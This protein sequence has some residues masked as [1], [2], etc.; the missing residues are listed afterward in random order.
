[1]LKKNNG[2]TLIELI[3][4][5]ALISIMAAASVPSIKRWVDSYRLND[6]VYQLKAS[7]AHAKLTSVK[8]GINVR[9][10]YTVGEAGAG[11]YQVYAD[12]GGGTSA[13]A[14]NATLDAGERILNEGS[15][16][17]GVNLYSATFGTANAS[18][19]VF[20]PAGLPMQTAAGAPVYFSGSV[21]V[22]SKGN[23]RRVSVSPGG[24]IKIEK[25]QVAT[26]GTWVE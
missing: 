12:D 5:I 11:T 23:F 2:F 15:M 8:E 3:I 17:L 14:N 22:S 10:V 9:V 1:M 20:N 16:P 6:G 21:N 13:N 25:S 24:S 4:V 18:T 19:T 7:L 26:G